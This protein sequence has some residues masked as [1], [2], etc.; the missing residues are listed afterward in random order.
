MTITSH[1]NRPLSVVAAVLALAPLSLALPA[2]ASAANRK[3]D[4]VRAELKR[5]TLN[6]DGGGRPNDVTLRL[7]K[8]DTSRIQVDVGDDRSAD[9]E[10]ARAD[11][12]AISI[13]MGSGR[14]SVHIDDGNGAFT[15]TIPTAIAGGQGD[16]SLNGGQGAESLSG[17]GG[18]DSIDGGRGN[19]TADLGR[20]EDTFTW[21][22][23][24]GSDVIEG[25]S[26]RDTMVFN[27]AAANEDV[28]LTANG[29]RLTF[30][31]NPASV[32]MDTDSV[33]TVDF[34]ALGGTDR[35]GVADLSGTD[36]RQLNV[37]L[38]G[39]LG[40]DAPDRAADSVILTGTDGD[41]TVHVDGNGSGADVTGLAPA[42]SIEH[43]D[44]NDPKDSLSINTLAGADNVFAA[45]VAG[46]LQVLVD[47]APV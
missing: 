14:D 30:F 32:T 40:G 2:G 29:G 43:A 47:G 23:G 1:H 17:G 46:V 41:D 44:A 28:A 20:G 35:I 18:D 31:R 13:A 10:F 9:F 5:G 33:E 6:V 7:K 25:G 4:G 15:D 19:D 39:S 26:G 37:D 22:P 34:N 21:D 38:A 8:D 16:D 36:V 24:E 45:G 12:H 27:G 11:V 3:V 42:V